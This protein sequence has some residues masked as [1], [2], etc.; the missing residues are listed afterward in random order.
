MINT[1]ETAKKIYIAIYSEGM[2]DIL[3]RQIDDFYKQ[4]ESHPAWIGGLKQNRIDKIEPMLK[5]LIRESKHDTLVK[6]NN[7]LDRIDNKEAK[8]I[9]SIRQEVQSLVYELRKEFP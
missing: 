9:K 8:D 3:C 7:I 1:T 4:G 6:L 2:K 5:E